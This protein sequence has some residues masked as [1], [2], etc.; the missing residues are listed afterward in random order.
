MRFSLQDVKKSIQRRGGELTVSPHFLRPGELHKE[1]SSLVAYHERLLGQPQRNFS[2][3]EA[4]ACVGDYRLANCLLATLSY[5]YVWRARD[6][7]TVV[8]ESGASADLAAMGSPTYLRLAL[9]TYV[10]EQHHGFLDA[11]QRASIM[12]E[13]AAQYQLDS[14]GIEYLLALDK[15]DEMLL[16]RASSEEPPT[17][18]DVATLYNQWVFEAALFNASEVRFTIDCRAFGATLPAEERQPATKMGPSLGVGAVIKRLC[19]LAR[20]LGVYY[21]LAYDYTLGDGQTPAFLTLT[22]YGPQEVSGAPQQYGLRLA[23]LC[24]L[25]LGYGI[26]DA[27]KKR[28][29]LATAIVDAAAT[30]HFLQRAYTFVIDARLLQL[31]PPVARTEHVIRETSTELF[32]SSIEQAFASAFM[33]LAA[34]H[35]VDGWQLERE[36]EPLLLANSIF[37]PDF[38]LTRDQKR[39]YVEI[40]GFWT[41]AYRE[42]KLQK[43]HQL[44]GRNDLLLAIPIEAR[45]AFAAIVADF[46]TVFYAGQLAVTD[47]LQVLR[48]SYDDFEERLAT[49]DVAA[50]RQHVQ[51]DG[52]V[53]ERSC[54]ALLHCYRRSELQK[55]AGLVLTTDSAFLAGV[56]LYSLSWMAPIKAELLTWLSTSGTAA[57]STTLEQL[58]QLLPVSLHDDAGALEALL[59]SWPEVEIRRDS[60]FAAQV[61]LCVG[62][63]STNDEQKAQERVHA[64]Q[65]QH[66]TK[67]RNKKQTRERRSEVKQ[68]ASQEPDVMQGGLWE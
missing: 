37:I 18:Q 33:G 36:P 62:D 67:K 45:D 1:I 48:S 30:V 41:P 44:R 3:D 38:A 39:I 52:L 51:A 59:A 2:V 68:R 57:L 40:L 55:A 24:R 26:K 23:R 25:L 32:D 20:K 13:F 10:N 16:T 11:A 61:A 42:R 7:H 15:E 9:Y 58:G 12:Q 21:E 4:R 29:T 53:P 6:W 14:A 47:I 19:Y 31:L 8:A 49:I 50:V 66:V 17:A 64:E 56:G 60:L 35:G 5:W 27:G 34:S 22:L 46:P 54:Y 63:S 43:L 28:P 65:E